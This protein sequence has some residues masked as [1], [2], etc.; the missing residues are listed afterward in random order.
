ML[1]EFDLIEE[2]WIPCIDLQG[3]RLE[4]GIQDTLLRAHELREIFHDSPLVTVALHR[5]LLALLY[6]SHSGPRDFEAWRLLYERGMFDRGCVTRYLDTWRDRFNLFD[7][8]YPFYQMASFE[9]GSPVS[10]NRLATECASGNNATLFDHS[11]DGEAPQ[12]PPAEAARQLLACQSFALGFGKAGRARIAGQDEDRPYSTDAIALRGLTIWLQGRT[13]FDTLAINLA[14]REDTSL[15]P[16]E[17]DD[18]HKYRDRL[19]GGR[20]KTAALGVV[21]RLTWQS[22]MVRL[23]P[24]GETVSLM[25]FTHGRSADKNPGD[26]MKAYRASR[27][28]GIEAVSLGSA[29]AVWRDAHALL[30]TPAPDSGERRPEC[31]NL[32][33]RARAREVIQPQSQYVAHVVGLATAP[34]KAGKFLLWRHERMPLPTD[35]LSNTR[36]IEALGRLLDK[37]EHAGTVLGQRTRRMASLYLSPSAE[38]RGGQEPDRDAVARLVQAIDPRPAYWARLERH[39]F[40]L[41]ANLA[42]DW[43]GVA[44]DWRPADEQTA[45]KAWREAVKREASQALEESIRALGTTSRAIQ[46]VARVRT[47]FNDIDLESPAERAARAKEGR[48]R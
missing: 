7:E 21:D 34:N 40:V 43:D 48:R 12:W 38:S 30:A 19:G 37:A 47:D 44:D 13:L 22:R 18:P 17:L 28:G 41:L 33:A 2:P 4:Y 24:D 11:S 29:K 45:S 26:P 3:R 1:T 8:R 32:V 31:F 46:A 20:Q 5:L 27:N 15:P 10:V 23:L 36:L 42:N 16:W 14:P 25:Y 35:L 6:R 9:T 39:F